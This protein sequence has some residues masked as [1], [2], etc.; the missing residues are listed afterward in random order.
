MGTKPKRGPVLLVA[1]AAL[2]CACAQ[3][4]LADPV[5]PAGSGLLATDQADAASPMPAWSYSQQLEIPWAQIASGT[6]LVSALACLAVWLLKKF[7]GRSPL[8]RGHYLDVLEARSVGRNVQLLLVRAAGKVVL[9]AVGGGSVACVAEFAADELPD[10]DTAPAG[11][12]LEGF[13]CLFKR[14]AGAQQ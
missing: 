3:A 13:R 2:A 11:H 6:L 12:G 10:L 14:L 7:N 9:I 1:V 5:A 4:A 8:S